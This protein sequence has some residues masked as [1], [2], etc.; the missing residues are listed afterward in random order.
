MII[1]TAGNAR[2]LR[3]AI[4]SLLRNDPKPRSIVVVDQSADTKTRDMIAA[5]GREEIRYVQ[6]ETLGKSAAVNFALKMLDTPLVGLLDDDVI[7]ESAWVRHALNEMD[8]HPEIAAVAGCIRPY[9]NGKRPSLVEPQSVTWTDTRE[10]QARGL[11]KGFGANIVVRREALE[12]IGGYDSRIG[13]GTRVGGS[14]DWDMLYRLLRKGL[15]AEYCPELVV[16]HDGWATKGAREEK[17]R[18][19]DR[20]RMAAHLKCW[21]E[22]GGP[23]LRDMAGLTLR[24]FLQ[25]VG[26]LAH[27]RR[28]TA[29][30][31]FVKF[32]RYMS[33]IPLGL[34]LAWEGRRRKHE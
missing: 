10:L 14:M 5:L 34:K 29:W 6:R 8:S 9:E 4:E 3:R 25:G 23:A 20:A 18:V 21:F 31:C 16:K 17:S 19:Y 22:V 13:P 28:G 2:K 26:H 15:R 7:V 27:R 24:T 1:P 12:A 32:G 30:S 33:G 11:M